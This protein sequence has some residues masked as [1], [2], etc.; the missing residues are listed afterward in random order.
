VTVEADLPT[1]RFPNMKSS[2]L[3]VDWT[4]LIAPCI[5]ALAALGIL[6]FW[7]RRRD[8]LFVYFIVLLTIAQNLVFYGS[9][10]FR[11]PIEPILVLLAAGSLWFLWSNMV[12]L[13][14]G[15]LYPQR[16]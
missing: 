3:V 16:L 15:K 4:K 11:A 13:R 2:Q 12:K 10:R 14:H 7:Q 5:F 1:S 9:P 8:L 6:A